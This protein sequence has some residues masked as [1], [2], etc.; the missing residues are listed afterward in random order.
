MTEPMHPTPEQ[1][2]P[3]K[4]DLAQGKD[5][6]RWIVLDPPVEMK[7]GSAVRAAFMSEEE[8][9]RWWAEEHGLL[10]ER[11]VVSPSLIGERPDG[12][13]SET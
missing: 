4:V 5:M 3:V 10:C 1:P 11:P 7:G 8:F 9:R 2:E 13:R 6:T 12:P